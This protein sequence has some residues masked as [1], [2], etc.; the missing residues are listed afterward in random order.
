MFS[1]YKL[2]F[3]NTRK[4]F[5]SA[6]NSMDKVQSDI[7]KTI[8]NN[9][10]DTKYGK[11]YKFEKISSILHYQN[12]VPITDYEDY[13]PYI[14]EIMHG[15]K[16]ILTS[17]DVILLEPTGG[18]SGNLKLIPYTKNLKKAFNNGIKPWLSDLFLNYP[19]IINLP[20]YWSISPNINQDKIKSK[21]KIGFENDIDYLENEFSQVIGKNL[22]IPPVLNN[23]NDFI[24]TSAEFLSKVNNIG[25]ISVWSP[26]LL[27]LFVEKLK[28]KPQ[29]IWK[30]LKIISAWDDGNSKIYFDKLK[31]L[32]P[33]VKL[34][35]KGL[36][37][38]EAITSIPIENIGKMPCV[39]SHFFEFADTKTHQIKLLHE[40]EKGENYTVIVTTQGGLYRYNTNDIINVYDFY[41]DCPLLKFISRGNN[42]SDYFG[43]KLNEI[44]V[45]DIIKSLKLDSISDFCMFAPYNSGKDFFYVLYLQTDK[46][47]NLKEIEEKIEEKLL[48]NFHYKYARTLNQ[49]KHFRIIKVKNG[50]MRYTEICQSRGQKIGDIKPKIFSNCI[51]W[52]F[53][54]EL[55]K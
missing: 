48:M 19:D 45:S 31:D 7:L 47:I 37:S 39:T 1:E 33:D 14:N 49:L 17:D 10:S 23:N 42:I 35:G 54:G 25:L 28:Q 4:E 53:M 13:C 22:T 44:F 8:L 43:E 26:A 24:S 50:I 30:N 38:T 6:I 34:Q 16:N 32:F 3:E 20:M 46:S 36:L 29:N 9:N 41:N 55:S 5:L 21:I 27:L 11:K 15:E 51:D 12:E 40:L 52:D 2:L 18:S